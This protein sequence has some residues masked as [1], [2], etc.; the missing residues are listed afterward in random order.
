M[1]ICILVTYLLAVIV[2]AEGNPITPDTYTYDINDVRSVAFD[3]FTL[4]SEEVI[5]EYEGE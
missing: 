4:A 1:T 3:S 2:F 5:A